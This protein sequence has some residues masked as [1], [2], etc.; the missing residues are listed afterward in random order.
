MVV[1]YA[2]SVLSLM[3]KMMTKDEMDSLI[4][5]PTFSSKQQGQYSKRISKYSHQELLELNDYID[6]IIREIK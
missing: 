3:E 5:M 6:E 1:S 2:S 4:A